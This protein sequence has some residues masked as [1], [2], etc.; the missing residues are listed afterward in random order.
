MMDMAVFW[1]DVT[2]L[3]IGT[4]LQPAFIIHQSGIL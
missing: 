4:A 2:L 1:P 3:A